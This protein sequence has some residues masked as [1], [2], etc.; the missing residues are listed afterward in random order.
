MPIT[1][2]TTVIGSLALAGIP[3]FAGFFSKDA[4]IEAVQLST[5]TGHTYARVALT[6]GVFVTAL[7]SFRMLF[8]AFHGEERFQFRPT[9]RRGD[10]RQCSIECCLFKLVP[11][12]WFQR[13]DDLAQ[14]HVNELVGHGIAE[15]FAE[16]GAVACQVRRRGQILIVNWRWLADP[17]WS[18]PPFTVTRLVTY[19]RWKFLHHR[20][21]IRAIG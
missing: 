9:M 6:L 17:R 16:A 12:G 21:P 13:L 20:R 2:W 1:Y 18:L 15:G 3:P 7:Y 19:R 10:D 8:L 5:V 14:H 11:W 4:I